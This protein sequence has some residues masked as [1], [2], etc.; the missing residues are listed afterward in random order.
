MAGLDRAVGQVRQGFGAALTGDQGFEHRASGD[1]EDVGDHGGQ[2]DMGVL[3]EFLGA[4]LV[5][6]ALVRHDRPGPGEVA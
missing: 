3:E 6:G 4:L 1:A 2:F 5:A